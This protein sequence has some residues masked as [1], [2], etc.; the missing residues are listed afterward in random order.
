MAG[1]TATYGQDTLGYLHTGDIFG[2]GLKTD[3]NHFLSSCCPL[4]CICS[5]EHDLTACSAG[6]CAQSLTDE[7]RAN[8]SALIKGRMKKGIKVTGIDHSNCFFLCSHAFINQITSYL[9]SCLSGTL[10]VTCLQH[11][12]LSVLNGEL[13]I[14][15]IAVVAL[16]LLAYIL[17]LAKCLGEFLLHLGYLH[18]CTNTCNHVFTLC[19]GKELTKEAFLAVCGVT[20]EG[21]AGTAVIT[22]VTECH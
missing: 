15:H 6:S 9:K 8:D 1:H 7:T 20:C 21:N 12:K 10:A 18:R 3:Q 17:E 22:H 11:V 4:F 16:K 19:I 13:H 14:L 2:R 5:G